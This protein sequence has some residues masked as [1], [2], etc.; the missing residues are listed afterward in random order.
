MAAPITTDFSKVKALYFD[1]YATLIDWEPSMLTAL[2]SLIQSLPESDPRRADT[3]ANQ[4]ALLRA[5]A[6]NEKAV[7]HEFPTMP[8][9]KILETVYGRL[10]SQFAVDFEEKDAVA[11]G[12]SIGAWAAFPD[13][14]AG[15]QTLSKY[16]KLFALSNVDNESFGRTLAGPLKG[17]KF[18]GIYTA[19][20]I[21]SYKPDPKNYKYCLE[22]IKT[23]FG[24]EAEE[25]LI[26]C[27]SLDI[28]H[29][30]TKALNLQPGIW[31]ARNRGVT[32]MGGNYEELLAAGKIK[33]G[34]T[35]D[36]LGELAAAV[37]QSLEKP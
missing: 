6:S 10:A 28:D 12:Y 8:Y 14:V 23:D 7:E 30:G 20:D 4:Q 32:A 9:P 15:M 22:H 16:Y 34:A 18:D 36:S 17:V 1:I 26:V 3:L 27:Q 24:I 2:S 19:Q 33:L 21:G 11:F 29:V 35:F 5:Y 37:E 13:S 31:I 25:A